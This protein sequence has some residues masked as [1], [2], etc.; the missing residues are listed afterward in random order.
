MDVESFDHAVRVAQET[1]CWDVF[2]EWIT[3]NSSFSYNYGASA[4]DV[5]STDVL[6]RILELL[7]RREFLALQGTSNIL[8]L[9]EYDWSTFSPDQ[10]NQVLTSVEQ[11]FP[12]F[13]DKLSWFL[14]AELLGEYACNHDALEAL[15]RL[16]RVADPEA[17]S[18]VASGF[19]QLAVCSS[20]STLTR[21]A[22]ASLER[23]REDPSALVR[24]EASEC[25][26]RVTNRYGI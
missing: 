20:D 8:R 22:S 21:A 4:Y 7:S 14:T 17:R 12:Y 9:I 10:R 2:E 25:I 11:A 1:G 15:Q 23:M 19:E 18:F 16:T 3:S 6:S 24:A 26:R 13:T 5:F